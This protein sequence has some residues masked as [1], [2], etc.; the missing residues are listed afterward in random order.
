MAIATVMA[1]RRIRAVAERRRTTMRAEVETGGGSARESD[2]E[3]EKAEWELSR[4]LMGESVSGPGG[5]AEGAFADSPAGE[6]EAGIWDGAAAPAGVSDGAEAGPEV[7]DDALFGG[8]FPWVGSHY[9]LQL[10]H[11]GKWGRLPLVRGIAARHARL[12]ILRD[13]SFHA[14]GGFQRPG[15]EAPL[16]PVGDER[17]DLRW[18]WDAEGRRIVIHFF[19]KRGLI[20][21]RWD[22]LTPSEDLRFPS[23]VPDWAGVGHVGGL[24]FRYDMISDVVEPPPLTRTQ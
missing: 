1:V 14:D 22:E 5:T 8:D 10:R 13:V 11:S 19:N 3:A 17:L 6:T 2:D 20:P 23:L 7:A 4:L 21:W 16:F 12:L 9:K 15:A 18:R 24:T